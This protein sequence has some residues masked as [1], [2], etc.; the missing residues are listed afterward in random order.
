[1]NDQEQKEKEIRKL[2]YLINK[3]GFSEQ[4]ILTVCSH[5]GWNPGR[6]IAE[7]HRLDQIPGFQGEQYAGEHFF[8]A[9]P[10]LLEEHSPVQEEQTAQAP[11]HAKKASEFGEDNTTFLWYPY[12]PRKEYTV[13]M[14]DGGT[15]KSF[16]CC[17][18]AAAITSG[19][20]L[21]GDDAVRAPGYVLFI[22]A[23][24][25]GEKFKSRLACAGADL[26][27]CF[28][29]DRRASVGMNFDSG[30]S[31]FRD[32]IMHYKPSLVILDPW[33]NFV[34]DSVDISRVNA[35]RP[36]L[37][38]LATIAG[39]CDC[40]IIAI[41]HVNKRAQGEN[42]NHAATGSTDFINAARSALRIVFDEVD[43]DI[44]LKEALQYCSFSDGPGCNKVRFTN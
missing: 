4:D 16:F 14:A 35:I 15:G 5:P 36:L 22:S 17:G 23:E 8:E 2:D 20:K 26:D 13:L 18:L 12:L 7:F 34:G 3:L 44:L 33:H 6:I 21:P 27:K 32:T 10:D 31:E 24:D 40:S 41:S 9:N 11:R 28:I 29:I 43:A 25:Y 42:A 1:M 37:Q 30:Y 19:R 39:D 38:R